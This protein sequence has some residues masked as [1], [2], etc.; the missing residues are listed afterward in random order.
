MFCGCGEVGGSPW[1]LV[2]VSEE[3]PAVNVPVQA[4]AAA[5]LPPAKLP[6]QYTLAQLSVVVL[7]VGAAPPVRASEPNVTTGQSK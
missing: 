5:V 7:H 6:W 3:A 2:Q 1:Q 4:G